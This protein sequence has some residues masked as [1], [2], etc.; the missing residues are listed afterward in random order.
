MIKRDLR[1]MLA[2]LALL[3]VSGCIPIEADVS[4]SSQ[5]HLTSAVAPLQ[6]QEAA[7][8]LGTSALE[9][10]EIPDCVRHALSEVSPGTRMVESKLFRAKVG[11]RLAQA[12]AVVKEEEI[13]AELQAIGVQ[14]SVA[15][16]AVRYIFL[17]KGETAEKG[18]LHT[19]RSTTTGLSGGTVT[20]WTKINVTVWDAPNARSSGSLAAN[21]Y[22]T[23]V[24]T[25]GILEYAPTESMACER[26]AGEIQRLL[27]SGYTPNP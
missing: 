16:L 3:A 26:M 10:G 9:D 7:V 6:P 8:I 20:R 25:V 11:G 27:K 1:H 15:E 23:L 18:S 2:L 21:G 17:V 13:V 19:S 5:L 24:K 14:Q 4:V 22:A 12:N